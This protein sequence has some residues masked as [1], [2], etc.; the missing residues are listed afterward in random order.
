MS[1][2]WTKFDILEM[3]NLIY[4]LSSVLFNFVFG[5]NESLENISAD[6][7]KI[8]FKMM[9]LRTVGGPFLS[10]YRHFPKS[11]TDKTKEKFYKLIEC[12][13]T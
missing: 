5:P 12:I 4:I 9:S 7:T 3:T 10:S 2:L 6:S 8:G 13:S 11:T 1:V